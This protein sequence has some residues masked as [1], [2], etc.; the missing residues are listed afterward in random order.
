MTAPRA[1]EHANPPSPPDRR[2]PRRG[3]GPPSPSTYAASTARRTAALARLRGARRGLARS[4]RM[5]AAAALLAL[6]GALALPAHGP[7]ADDHLV[8]T[9]GRGGEVAS[10][11]GFDP[12]GFSGSEGNR[13]ETG[14][15][16]GTNSYTI[17]ECS[18][19]RGYDGDRTSALTAADQ[20]TGSACRRQRAECANAVD[21]V[22]SGTY[23]W[24]VHGGRQR[25][26]AAARRLQQRPG[27]LRRAMAVHVAGE[28]AADV[29]V[30]TVTAT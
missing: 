2:P 24:L 14:I 8:S 25:H 20:A 9:S 17:T 12:G 28:Q 21:N 10:V 19:Q 30:G 1:R 22:V 7:G 3:G 27:I 26:A 16:T 18:L 4:A 29:V 23:I 6:S 5:L 13:S 15:P 11:T